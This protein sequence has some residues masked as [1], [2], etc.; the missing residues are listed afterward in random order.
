MKVDVLPD[1]T[2]VDAAVWNG[3]LARSAVSSV[4]LTWEWQTAWARAFAPGR[5]VQLLTLRADDGSIAALLPLYEERDG[6]WRITGGADVS[7]YLDLIAPAGTEEE[8]WHTLL[9]HRAAHGDE[10]DLC[11]VR[12]ASPTAALLPVLAPSA[13]LR[14]VVEVQDRCPILKLPATW[15]A[16]L[17][18]LSGK[19]R[20]E[21]RRKMRKL[22]RELPGVTVRSHADARGWD[23]ALG[24]FLALHRRSK[25]GKARFMDERMERFFRDATSALVGRGW[26]RLWFLESDGVPVATFLCIE[27]GDTVGLYNSGFDPVHARLA[28]GI[29]L[30]AHV[31]KD[32]IDRGVPVFDF[33]R[34]EE[35]YKRDFGPSPEHLLNIRILP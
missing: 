29:V 22:P 32:A 16:Y 7:D 21:L 27:H 9:Q 31:I 11:A 18:T 26:A 8:A 14:T 1:L 2:A 34:G 10:W 35:S 24:A 6:C 13:G 20:H 3:L 28:P 25:V 19:D 17:A 30:L 23:D 4:F 5:A 12:A 33:L 15:D